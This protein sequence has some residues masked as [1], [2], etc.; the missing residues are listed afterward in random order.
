MR[1][2]PLTDADRRAMLTKIGVPSVDSLYRDVP[3]FAR[4][5][6]PVD[7]PAYQGELEVERAIGAMAAKN[8][9]TSAVPSFL[10]AGAYRHHVPA[11][12]VESVKAASEVYAPL[13]GE[14]V[15][16]NA[17]LEGEPAKVNAEPMAGGWFLKLKV[18]NAAEV[19]DLMD[20]AAYRDYVKGL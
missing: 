6:K 16:V 7:L 10:G 1:Y 17:A 3:D 4:L 12:V 11:A 15:E 20:E 14:V 9:G 5:S 13:S 19:K 18:Q 8:L 2:L